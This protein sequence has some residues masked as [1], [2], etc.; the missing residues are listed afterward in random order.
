MKEGMRIDREATET[1]IKAVDPVR[2]ETD[3]VSKIT[4]TI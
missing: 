3:S 1:F 2:V 4:Y